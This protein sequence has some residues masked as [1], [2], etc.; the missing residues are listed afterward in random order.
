MKR[1]QVLTKLRAVQSEIAEIKKN[2]FKTTCECVFIHGIGMLCEANT[3][4]GLIKFHAAIS[5]A[6]ATLEKSA[7]ELQIE[8]ADEEFEYNGVQFST[9]MKDIK[10][11]KESIVADER[12]KKL[13][14]AEKAL[15]KHL[16]D[17]DIFTI[18]MEEISDTL[19]S[20]K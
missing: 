1:E 7:K 3:L 15:Q 4:Q 5:H 10:T 14:E 12:L 8:L 16:S 17:D 18:D 13:I 6:K 2:D 9:W 19:D 20:V 11:I